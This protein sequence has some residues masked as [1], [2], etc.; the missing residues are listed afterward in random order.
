M[1]RYTRSHTGAFV[2][3]GVVVALLL[4]GLLSY[5]ASAKPDGLVSTAQQIGFVETEQEHA[6]GD[7][8]FS[9]YTT[10]GIE[11]ARLSTAVAGVVGVLVTL[12][13]GGLL[14]LAV[15][16]RGRSSEQPGDRTQV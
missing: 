10:S 1:L 4:A 12:A 15:R 3:V 6:R 16:R 14:F 7:S 8:T 13:A 11:N 9:G 2:L 5:Y